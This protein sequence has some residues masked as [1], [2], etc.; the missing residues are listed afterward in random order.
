MSYREMVMSDITIKKPFI[1][2]S[3]FPDDQLKNMQRY[4][5]KMWSTSPNYDKS[6]GR[7]QWAN[8]EELKAFHNQLTELAREEF[9]SKTLMPSWNLLSIYEGEDAK[10]W[11]HKDDNACV[12][13]IDFCVFQKT[14]WGLWV[15]HEDTEEEYV[16]EENDGLFMYGNDQVHW[17]DS[18]PDP[19]N[20][21]VAN[22]F[23]F[24][25]EP[26]HWYFT[27]GP[28]Y[29]NNVIRKK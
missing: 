25:V 1:L 18:F 19:K 2:K 10:L 16:L 6:F 9:G 24:F 5:M 21:L 28:E 22:A 26:D 15:E 20:N 29:L 4:T 14:P 27:E 3:I 17:R 13:H 23:F 11:K 12:Y 8:T 7:H